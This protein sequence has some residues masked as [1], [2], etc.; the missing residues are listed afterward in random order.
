MALRCKAPSA[1]GAARS[2]SSVRV[3]CHKGALEKVQVAAASVVAAALV[4]SPANA[5][6]ILQQPELKKLFQEDAPA[7]APVKREY[8][9]FSVGLPSAPAPAEAEKAAEAPK[10][11][12]VEAAESSSGLDL[13][14]RSIA[15]P[16]A[17][18]LTIGG[19]FAASKIDNGFSEWIITATVKDSN[20]IG[21]GYEPAIKT[22]GGA[23]LKAAAG[24]KK[25][26][27]ATKKGGSLFG[28]K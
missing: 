11:K 16:G 28:K 21:A 20:D 13:D 1:V 7:P 24:T 9:P 5:G 14:P 26:K 22:D 23:V 12:K 27:A 3:V 19:F 10:A 2:R 15:L 6:V 8:K 4:A 25:V 17:L 18:A